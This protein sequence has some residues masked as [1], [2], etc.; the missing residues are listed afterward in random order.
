MKIEIHFNISEGDQYYV[1]DCNE[2]PIVT[3]G[4]TLDKTIANIQEA[5]QLHLEDEDLN[6]L[7]ISKSPAVSINLDLGELEYA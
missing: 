7:M 6:E 5:L 3:Q 2:L 4:K 1:A